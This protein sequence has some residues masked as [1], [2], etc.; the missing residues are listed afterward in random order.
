MMTEAQVAELI[1]AGMNCESVEVEGDG[2][3]FYVSV[4]SSEFA[5]KRPIA[6]QQMVY[7][8]VKEQIESGELHALSFKLTKTPDEM[9][10]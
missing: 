1:K 4:I 3:H 8:A 6:R 9:Q 7:A 10:A 5:G 2:Q